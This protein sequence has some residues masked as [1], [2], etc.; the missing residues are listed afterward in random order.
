[1][2][3]VE[4]RIARILERDLAADADV[5]L[6]AEVAL[7]EGGLN[8]DSVNLLELIVKVEEAFGVTIEDEDISAEMFS[9][10]GS[11]A[12]FV[13]QKRAARLPSAESHSG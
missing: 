7:A 13:R 8:L 2:D 5:P 9:T 4:L 11:L 1:M 10:L 3:E 6:T 12:A